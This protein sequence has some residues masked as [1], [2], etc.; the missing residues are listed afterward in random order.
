[1]LRLQT[2]KSKSKNESCRIQEYK[3]TKIHHYISII[4]KR[5]VQI[6]VCPQT[7]N[8]QSAPRSGD[9]VAKIP[10]EKCGKYKYTLTNTH[11]QIHKKYKLSDSNCQ[12][13]SVGRES[14]AKK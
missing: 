11:K 12:P 2:E 13:R 5:E 7:V 3:K 10:V 8:W 6:A 4:I 9:T 1:M 14:V